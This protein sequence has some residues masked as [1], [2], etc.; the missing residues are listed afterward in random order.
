MIYPPAAI[1]IVDKLKQK[2][3]GSNTM[4][5][6]ISFGP[7]MNIRAQYCINA[8]M[9]RLFMRTNLKNAPVQLFDNANFISL[10]AY[11]AK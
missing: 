1:N 9:S 10:Y 8:N 2:I 4:S 3:S 5:K 6:K 7:I 11:C